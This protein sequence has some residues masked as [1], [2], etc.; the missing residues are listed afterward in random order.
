MEKR[1]PTYDLDSIKSEFCTVAR[2]RMT[3]TA[4]NDAL[5]LGRPALLCCM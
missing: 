4:R 5:G 3:R 1:R 2:L